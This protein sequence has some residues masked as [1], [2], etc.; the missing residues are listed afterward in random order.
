MVLKGEFFKD[1]PW[2]GLVIRSRWWSCIRG[3]SPFELGFESRVCLAESY[4]CGPRSILPFVGHAWL[5][6]VVRGVFH[7]RVV[8]NLFWMEFFCNFWFVYILPQV[9]TLYSTF[10][11]KFA[12]SW[13]RLLNQCNPIY[14]YCMWLVSL[15][16]VLSL[17][18]PQK[19]CIRARVWYPTNQRMQLAFTISWQGWVSKQKA[20]RGRVKNQQI[21]MM[22]VHPASSIFIWIS[23]IW[24]K[25]VETFLNLKNHST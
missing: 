17:S 6:M 16:V 13:S 11:S 21:L 20:Q 24:M 8:T 3:F 9:R 1:E 2:L 10:R 18:N 12:Y 19:E 15:S 7:S 4:L 22:R 25:N 23:P 14:T 5:V